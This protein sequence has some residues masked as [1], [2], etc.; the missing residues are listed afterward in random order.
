MDLAATSVE[1]SSSFI[2]G[3]NSEKI[4]Q[5]VTVSAIDNYF[6]FRVE[7]DNSRGATYVDQY[8]VTQTYAQT[9]E[10]RLMFWD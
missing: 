4:E 10:Y 1:V 6:F 8:G 9:G 7:R 2:T 5:T 3:E